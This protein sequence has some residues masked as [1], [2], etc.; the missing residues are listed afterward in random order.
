MPKPLAKPRKCFRLDAQE[1]NVLKSFALSFYYFNF[2]HWGMLA[3]SHF[4]CF[5][6]GSFNIF[7]PGFALGTSRKE[8]LREQD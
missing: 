8:L 4:H 3:K 6:L 7:S 1:V 5:T 2:F